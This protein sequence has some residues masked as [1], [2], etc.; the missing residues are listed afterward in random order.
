VTAVY[1]LG[2]FVVINV[3]W[4]FAARRFRWRS[5]LRDGARRLDDEP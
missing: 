3:V 1:A 4:F 2:G 5:D